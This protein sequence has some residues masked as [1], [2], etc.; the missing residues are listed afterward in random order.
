MIV[1]NNRQVR[2]GRI[3]PKLGQTSRGLITGKND[4]DWIS[5]VTTLFYY[6]T[7]EQ[8]RMDANKI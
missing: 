7:S 3:S 6:K 5:L 1:M 8:Y 4:L 2:N